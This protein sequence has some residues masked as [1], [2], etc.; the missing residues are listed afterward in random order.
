MKQEMDIIFTILFFFAESI[1]NTRPIVYERALEEWNTN[2]IGDM[3]ADYAVIE[4]YVKRKK[5]LTGLL[6]YANMLTQWVIVW[7]D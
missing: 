6:F 5:T 7:E 3:Y 2:T 1:D 4:K